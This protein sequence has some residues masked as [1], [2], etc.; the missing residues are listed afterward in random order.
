MGD[1]F[2]FFMG[3]SEPSFDISKPRTIKSFDPDLT[4]NPFDT[5]S[6]ECS[7][8]IKK[9]LQSQIDHKIPKGRVF[10]AD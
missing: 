1:L 3:D 7:L 9:K 10:K 5:V 2:M 8:T 6:Q 4:Q